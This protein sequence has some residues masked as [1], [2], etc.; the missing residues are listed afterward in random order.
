VYVSVTGIG[1][2]TGN[3]IFFTPTN[4]TVAVGQTVTVSLSGGYGNYY[5]SNSTNPMIQTT[6]NGNTLTIYGASAGSTSV[7]IC[8]SGDGC[9]T[10]YVT[11]GG[12][13][14]YYPYYSSTYDTSSLLAQIQALKN[15]LAQLE[16]QA[17]NQTGLGYGY[18]YNNGITTNSYVFINFL[19]L[20]SYGEEVT[21]LQQRLTQEGTYAGPITGYFGYMTQQAVRSYQSMHGLSPVGSVGP[22][23][24]ALLNGGYSHNY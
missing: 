3:Q 8:S 24:R 17:R 13:G 19:T 20:G 23:T 5:I 1:G 12:S 9:G 10:L 21:Q 7:T 16:A 18:V 11:V 22:Q 6:I 15:Q 4:P 14:S 2:G